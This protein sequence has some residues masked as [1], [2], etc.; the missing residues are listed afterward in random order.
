MSV[1]SKNL[2]ALLG[3]DTPSEAPAAE[4]K[5]TPA[6]RQLTA[7][8]TVSKKRDPSKPTPRE[9]TVAKKAEQPRK[10]SRRQQ[11]QGNAAAFREG[12]EAVESNLSH[13]TEGAPQGRPRRGRQFDRRS[14]TGRVDTKK[15]T[16]RGWGNPVSS[17]VNADS[18]EPEEGEGSAPATPKEE[19][20]VKTLDEYLAEKKSTA[21]PVG[22]TVTDA[23]VDAKW[24]KVT[25]LERTEPE[26]LFSSVKKTAS[27]SKK[28][29]DSKPKKVVLEIEQT[30]GPRNTNTR[31]A[32]AP[33]G[34]APRKAEAP[35]AATPAAPTLTE[36]EFPSLGA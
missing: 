26:D 9:R 32:R 17:E 28:S 35:K 23:D 14:A 33:R 12:R 30:F 19:D 22:R 24:A 31:G 11:P 6:P 25:K 34:R 3:E 21:K 5:P 15:A 7:K 1:A 10:S 36:E 13:P 29:K 16:E 20:N 8:S 4:T 18:A 2:F 27:G